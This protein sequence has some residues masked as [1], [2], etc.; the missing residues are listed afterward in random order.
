MCR[1][2]EVEGVCYPSI[3]SACQA[4]GFTD[5]KVVRDRLA[6]GESVCAELFRPIEKRG[7]KREVIVAG[8]KYPSIK[9]AA[10]AYGI[11]AQT[12]RCRIYRN[13][14]KITDACFKSRRPES[15]WKMVWPEADTPPEGYILLTKFARKY[16]ALKKKHSATILSAIFHR[17]ELAH[18]VKVRGRVWIDEAFWKERQS[19]FTLRM[20]KQSMNMTDEEAQEFCEKNNLGKKSLRMFGF[21]KPIYYLPHLITRKHWTLEQASPQGK[22]AMIAN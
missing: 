10:H 22:F 11:E 21:V 13:G 16:P 9:A 8:I 18:F 17:R 3:I 14:G 6:R 1:K 12:V 15:F 20:I 2:I 19:W 5:S 4:Y 7:G